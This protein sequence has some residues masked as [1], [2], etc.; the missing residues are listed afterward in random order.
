M[1][2]ARVDHLSDE[3]GET[4]PG[5]LFQA[6]EALS[7]GGSS[8][9]MAQLAGRK[10]KRSRK[11]VAAERHAELSSEDSLRRMLQTYRC[12]CARRNCVA[13]FP[14]AHRFQEL[15]SFRQEWASLHKLDQDQVVPRLC[16][17]RVELWGLVYKRYRGIVCVRA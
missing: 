14:S 2:F 8:E 7:D 5:P 9:H 10:R 15:L 17:Y 16:F 1:A 4:K 3:D 6:V 11:I 13:V 12:P